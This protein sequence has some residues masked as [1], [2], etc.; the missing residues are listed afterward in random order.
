M[1]VPTRLKLATE[2]A[3]KRV[4]L[5]DADYVEADGH[6]AECLCESC[7]KFSEYLRVKV[8]VV[9]WLDFFEETKR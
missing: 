5:T 4:G 8:I 6:S 1:G 7:E 2:F 9:E 3:R